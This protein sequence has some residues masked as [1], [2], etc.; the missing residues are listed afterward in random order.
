MHILFTINH[1]FTILAATVITLILGMPTYATINKQNSI[2]TVTQINPTTVELKTES[3]IRTTIDF[4]G[5]NIIRIFRDNTGGIIR[6]PQATPEA[7][8]LT[9]TPRK[10]VNKLKITENDETFTI[11]TAS[12]EI[13]INKKNGQLK[14]KNSSNDKIVFEEIEPVEFKNNKTTIPII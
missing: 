7:K 3:N 13:I 6:D 11:T 4:Y 14:A 8:I 2:T 9:D 10:P 12:M 1:K 5:E